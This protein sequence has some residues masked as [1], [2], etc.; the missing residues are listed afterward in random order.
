MSAF[1]CSNRHTA[2]IAMLAHAPG[3]VESAQI[4]ETA[5]ILRALNDAALFARYRDS[6]E[7][8]TRADLAGAIPAAAEW[9]RQSNP[10]D[11]LAAVR[12]FAYQC[13]ED[14]PSDYPGLSIL[15]DVTARLSAMASATAFKSGVWSI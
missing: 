1:R 7:P 15:A 10:A 5:R 12:C 8:L 11:M 14:I 3:V 2:V 9:M 4:A 6:A 13:A